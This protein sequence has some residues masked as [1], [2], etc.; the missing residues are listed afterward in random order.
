MAV[1]PPK[2]EILRNG[3]WYKAGDTLP[4]PVE[5]KPAET[6]A[7]AAAETE[8]PKKGKKNKKTASPA[9]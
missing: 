4:G 2:Q 6:D 5:T 3:I 7:P 1:V 9:D 8:T